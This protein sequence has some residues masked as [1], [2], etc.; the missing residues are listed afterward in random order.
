MA[1]ALYPKHVTD[2]V[3]ATGGRFRTASALAPRRAKARRVAGGYV[4]LDGLRM[5][6]SGVYHAH[7]NQLGTSLVGDAGHPIGRG[8]PLSPTTATAFLND[9]DAIA[10]H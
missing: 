7:W 4:I 10:P 2:Q 6:N 5:Y 8:S 3:F 1:A 9:W